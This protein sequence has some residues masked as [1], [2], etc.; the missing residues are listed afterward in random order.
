MGA[1]YLSLNVDDVACAEVADLLVKSQVCSDAVA[2]SLSATPERAVGDTWR[3]LAGVCGGVNDALKK[4]LEEAGADVHYEKRVAALDEQQ[5]KWRARPFDGAPGAFDAVVLAV[6]GCGVGGDNLNKIRGGYEAVFSP[7]Q[8]RQLLS[9]QHDARWSFALFLSPECLSYCDAFFGPD[10]LERVIDD[11]ALHLLCYQSRKTARASGTLQT[12]PIA[13]VAHTTVE[14]AKR[15]A[16]ANGR[17]ERLLREISELVKTTLGLEGPTAKLVL[18]SK[19]ITWKQS[20]VTKAL[21]AMPNGPCMMASSSPA[22]VLAGDYFTDSSF[23]GCLK[24]GF[25]AADAV[26]SALKG[27]RLHASEGGEPCKGK[28]KDKGK[29]KGK[30]KDKDK[31]EKGKGAGGKKGKGK[32]ESA[33]YSE[34]SWGGDTATWE[35][36]G[37]GGKQKGGKKGYGS[38]PYSGA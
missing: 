30:G 23:G 37:D 34:N 38:L 31:G 12:G 6:P 2:A 7:E 33:G 21:P 8:N 35:K 27:K 22:L 18:A 26:A 3:H 16:R 4:L 25:A 17:D 15:N 5:G 10:S 19:V 36:R 24:S 28:G 11:G 1:Q 14:W 29:D 20:Q 13:I 32:G 9:A